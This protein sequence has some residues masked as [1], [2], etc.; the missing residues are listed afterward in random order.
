MLGCFQPKQP[1]TFGAALL[2]A[3]SSSAETNESALLSRAAKYLG[4]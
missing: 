2:L 1:S 4:A 3:G